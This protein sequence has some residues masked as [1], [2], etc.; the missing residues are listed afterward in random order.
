[1]V[2]L[3]R[4]GLTQGIAKFPVALVRAENL[5]ATAQGTNFTVSPQSGDV[6]LVEADVSG[7]ANFVPNGLE[8]STVDLSGEFSDMVIAQRAYSSVAQTVRV[9]DEMTQVATCLKT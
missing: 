9:V 8:Q 2:G 6:H 5:L 3:F 7:F 1:V 4:N